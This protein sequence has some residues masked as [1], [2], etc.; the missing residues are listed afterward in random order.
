MSET[1]ALLPNERLPNERLPNERRMSAAL[2]ASRGAAPVGEPRRGAI[3]SLLRGIGST[4]EWIFGVVTLIGGLAFLATIPILQFLSLGYLLESGGRIARSGRMRDGFVGVRKA[5]RV[6]GI[7]LGA[8]LLLLPLRLVSSMATS[9][10]IIDPDGSIAQRWARA[11]LILAILLG[12]H[13]A[14]ACARG[15]RL[16]HFFWPFTHPFWFIGR[17]RRGGY[18]A[19]ARDAV[20]DFVVGLRLPHYFWLG[21]RGYVGALAWIFVPVSLIAAGRHAPL[22]GFIGALLL[23]IV[24]LYLPFLHMRLA[25]ENRFRAMFEV[26]AVRRLFQRAPWAFAFALLIALASALPLYLL[27][28]EMIPREAAWL[29]SLVFVMFIYPARFLAG[30]AYG[31]A[32]HRETPRHWF[33]RWTG[34]LAMLPVVSFYVLIVYF[35]QFTAWD[36]IY[37]LYEQH[38][39][40]LPVPFLGM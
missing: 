25:A 28:I 26:R 10:Q 40:L 13:I 33:F 2:T 17:L 4:F 31:R 37:S 30:W 12:I 35:T 27:K 23:G 36:G 1:M 29:P 8:W 9:A 22:L 11:T 7:V 21:F 19:E 15:G 14:L 32:A 18:F 39:F 3:R 24:V 34:R 38:A 20:W 16:R 5:A 6:G